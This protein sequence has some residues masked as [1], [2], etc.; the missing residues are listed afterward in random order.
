MLPRARGLNK[1]DFEDSKNIGSCGLPHLGELGMASAFELVPGGGTDSS[2]LAD[3]SNSDTISG[4]AVELNW[5]SQWTAGLR[6]P[7]EPARDGQQHSLKPGQGG[8][9]HPPKPGQDS[10]HHLPKPSHG[11]IAH[12][13]A[14]PSASNLA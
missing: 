6:H 9:Q 4:F 8:Q 13:E 11:L 14:V 1:E 3:P 7:S 2:C 12:F 5:R 10:E